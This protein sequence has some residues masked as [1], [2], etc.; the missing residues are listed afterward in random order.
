MSLVKDWTITNY[1][2]AFQTDFQVR[3]RKRGSDWATKQGA[4]GGVK[5]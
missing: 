4:H 3:L 2:L 1:W 5:V